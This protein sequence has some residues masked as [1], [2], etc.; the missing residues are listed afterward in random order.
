MEET[1]IESIFGT[2]AGI[3][4]ESL[5]KDGPSTIGNLAKTTSL[6]REDIHGALGWL[7][8]EDKISVERQGRA[9]VFSLRQ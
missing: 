9:M 3:V 4:W 6:S 1:T 7:G 5:N 8:R 2:N